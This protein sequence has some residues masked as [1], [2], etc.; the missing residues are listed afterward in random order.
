MGLEDQDNITDIIESLGAD[1][2]VV[3]A[4]PEQPQPPAPPEEPQEEAIPDPNEEIQR[5]QRI[6]ATDPQKRALYEHEKYGIPL[7]QPTQQAE[8]VQ[9]GELS[10]EDAFAN[11]F[12]GEDF[13][14][15]NMKHQAFLQ[16]MNLK[17]AFSYIEQLQ[18]EEQELEKRQAME[19]NRQ[20]VE[21]LNKGV[22]DLFT[23]GLPIVGDLLKAESLTDEQAF[24]ID[25]MESKFQKALVE[26]FPER[27]DGSHIRLWASPEVHK[28]IVREILPPLKQLAAK[29]GLAQEASKT[30]NQQVARET[31]VESSNAVPS[32]TGNPFDDAL[33]KGDVA[34]ALDAFD[35]KFR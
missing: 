14:P 35:K 4:E 18:K 6:I 33:A 17:P 3:E 9:S 7:P 10:L 31:Y 23:K 12:P 8:Q 21:N 25:A 1:E 27:P 19:A 2:P 26:R 32:T 34:S 5:L 30:V 16:Q 13:D 28:E 11:Q 20:A 29:L 15:F 22:Q 24:L